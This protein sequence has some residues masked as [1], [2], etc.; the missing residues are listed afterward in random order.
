MPFPFGKDY[1]GGRDELEEYKIKRDMEMEEALRRKGE[2]DG[3]KNVG[4]HGGE[5][6]ESEKN[7][8]AD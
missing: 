7:C 4:V 6:K 5:D 3:Q 8:R 2:Q 1:T